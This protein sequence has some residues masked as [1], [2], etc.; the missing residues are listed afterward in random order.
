MRYFF[1][2][3]FKAVDVR[4]TKCD[5][6]ANEKN[7]KFY[8]LL[9]IQPPGRQNDYYKLPYSWGIYVRLRDGAGGERRYIELG[10]YVR[11]KGGAG[12]VYRIRALFYFLC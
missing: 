10:I 9:K 2:S 7:K 5:H 8:T 1:I 12:E 4:V 3:L 11:L 6:Q